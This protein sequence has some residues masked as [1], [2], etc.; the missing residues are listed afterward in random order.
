M[1]RIPEITPHE[2]RKGFYRGSSPF[3]HTYIFFCSKGCRCK[4]DTARGHNKE[5]MPLLPK[6][7]SP[8]DE[9][10]EA[11]EDFWGLYAK[12]QI[13]M[14]RVIVWN[15]SCISPMLWFFAMRIF[16]WGPKGDLQNAAVPAT[17]ALSLLSLFWAFFTM[18]VLWDKGP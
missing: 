8:F 7:V 15:V 11:R 3:T 4:K 14:L 18:I 10:T 13:K 5:I 1:T 2:F 17:L 16:V 6:R 9:N 12:N